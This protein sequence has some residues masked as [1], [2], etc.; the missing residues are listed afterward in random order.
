M[1]E[2]GSLKDGLGI[3]LYLGIVMGC[4]ESKDFECSA[5]AAS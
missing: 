3:L 5:S 4:Q 2:T 1:C